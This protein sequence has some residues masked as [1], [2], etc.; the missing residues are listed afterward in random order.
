M[1]AANIWQNK[2]DKAVN[3]VAA[4]YLPL[5]KIAEQ[6][7]V[8]Y[9]TFSKWL[10]DPNFKRKL[11]IRRDEIAAQILKTGI[12]DKTA[13]IAKANKRWD[14]LHQIIE[15]RAAD[16]QFEGVPGGKTGLLSHDIKSVGSGPF[17]RIVDYF[18][19]DTGLL[20]EIRQH[21]TMVSEDLGQRPRPDSGIHVQVNAVV[22]L[23]SPDVQ[24]RQ[25]E[26]VEAIDIAVVE[27]E[28]AK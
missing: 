3:L 12:A 8:K 25:L 15:E 26:Q 10:E 18:E 14:G 28:Q 20:N 22:Q 21:E 19:V 13:R 16:P 7:G 11:A 5:D 17:Q 27:V 4:D 24:R 2:R 6:C 1:N 9:R 23:P